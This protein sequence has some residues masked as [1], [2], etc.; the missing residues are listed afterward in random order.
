MNPVHNFPPSC[1]KIHFNIIFPYAKSCMHL[2][3]LPS[4]PPRFHHPLI[5]FGENL[6]LKAFL[7]SEYDMGILVLR[8]SGASGVAVLLV[9][10][11]CSSL[12][13]STFDL[14]CCPE[15]WHGSDWSSFP[16]VAATSRR[17]DIWSHGDKQN[18]TG[19]AYGRVGC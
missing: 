6:K 8:T 2:S 9:S 15:T 3:D 13:S 12:S 1:P 11:R 14:A 18:G 17:Y 7:T 5:I 16:C 19:R 4:H 10:R